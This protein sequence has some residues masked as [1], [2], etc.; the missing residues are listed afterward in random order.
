VELLARTSKLQEPPN[1]KES[2]YFP[3]VGASKGQQSD[4]LKGSDIDL[5]EIDLPVPLE[6]QA[7]WNI[8]LTRKAC[9]LA[10]HGDES[11]WRRVLAYIMLSIP[12]V[13]NNT[14]LDWMV[15]I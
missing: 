10:S 4:E 9:S 5:L 13:L 12:L 1:M 11:F 15:A 6:D 7:R 3:N 8:S 14:K 2:R